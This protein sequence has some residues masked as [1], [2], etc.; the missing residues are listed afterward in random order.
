MRI[1]ERQE[2]RI[3]DPATICIG[4]DR[5]PGTIIGIT[6]FVSGAKK[7]LVRKVTVQEDNAIIVSG[8]YYDPT[9][10]YTR[11]ED[12]RSMTFTRGHDGNFRNDSYF[13]HIGS[14]RKYRDPSF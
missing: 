8:D 12:G 2:P 5:Y 6:R 7:G 10:E 11:N 1:E 13:C 14:R 4:S 3:H 9:Y